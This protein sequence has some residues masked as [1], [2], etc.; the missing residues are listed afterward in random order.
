MTTGTS[1]PDDFMIPRDIMDKAYADAKA[2]TQIL[3]NPEEIC[4]LMR[5][6]DKAL[7]ERP[8]ISGDERSEIVW[9]RDRLS[10]YFEAPERRRQRP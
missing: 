4:E 9:V 5:C 2:G 7:N 1:R 6:L 10:D 3:V 8:G